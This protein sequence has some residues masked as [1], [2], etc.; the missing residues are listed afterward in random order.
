MNPKNMSN[1][2]LEPES[3]LGQINYLID[4]VNGGNTI[5][6][7]A[8]NYNTDDI[9]KINANTQNLVI[10]HTQVAGQPVVQKTFVQDNDDI[11]TLSNLLTYIQQAGETYVSSY[12]LTP[13]R[14]LFF[15]KEEIMSNLI[16][17]VQSL[18][19]PEANS[20]TPEKLAAALSNVLV[21]RQV[22]SEAM[23]DRLVK[24]VNSADNQELR[25]KILSLLK[26]KV[27]ASKQYFD[28]QSSDYKILESF[29]QEAIAVNVD[30]TEP[31][32]IFAAEELRWRRDAPQVYNNLGFIG[33]YDHLLA[34]NTYKNKA[35]D[36]AP[37]NALMRLIGAATFTKEEFQKQ[38]RNCTQSNVVRPTADK[39]FKTL[40]Q[41]VTMLADWR[42]NELEKG[43]T[44]IKDKLEHTIADK[45]G[46]AFYIKQYAAIKDKMTRMQNT[47]HAIY[48]LGDLS[49]QIAG[50][51]S[52][53][54]PIRQE[55]TQK[56]VTI[57]KSG[58]QVL[59]EEIDTIYDAL[60][61]S[62]PETKI[63]VFG[64]YAGNKQ[65]IAIQVISDE[66]NNFS[67]K[68]D[69][70]PSATPLQKEFDDHIA[71]QISSAVI[72]K[73][74]QKSTNLDAIHELLRYS[75][76]LDG[77]NLSEFRVD[78]LLDTIVDVLKLNDPKLD[79]LGA[80]MRRYQMLCLSAL[81]KVFESYESS[82]R[83]LFVRIAHLYRSHIKKLFSSAIGSDRK[84]A[85][86]KQILLVEL[87]KSSLRSRIDEHVDMI[88]N[89]NFY[90]TQSKIEKLRQ[91]EIALAENIPLFNFPEFIVPVFSHQ[92]E[93]ADFSV[94][95]YYNILVD[96][97]KQLMNQ[98]NIDLLV[99]T[100][101]KDA[102]ELRVILNDM[103]LY[104][105]ETKQSLNDFFNQKVGSKYHEPTY[106]LVQSFFNNSANRDKVLRKRIII[107]ELPPLVVD[108]MCREAIFYNTT[109]P[110]YWIKYAKQ[111]LR[112]PILGLTAHDIYSSKYLTPII[113]DKSFAPYVKILDL[114]DKPVLIA[115]HKPI[116]NKNGANS[117]ITAILNEELEALSASS[118]KIGSHEEGTF[119]DSFKN[120]VTYFLI[121][122][123]F[124]EHFHKRSDDM[125]REKIHILDA[126]FLITNTNGIF[127]DR[128]KDDSVYFV[129]TNDGSSII[130][131]LQTFIRYMI[132]P[133]H[134][135]ILFSFDNLHGDRAV[136]RVFTKLSAEGLEGGN[137]N[138]QF[139]LGGANDKDA[140]PILE[141]VDAIYI[142]DMFGLIL[143]ELQAKLDWLHVNG[144]KP[145]RIRFHFA[146]CWLGSASQFYYNTI[147]L[148]DS[149]LPTD[150]FLDK[151]TND[152]MIAVENDKSFCNLF[153]NVLF[154]VDAPMAVNMSGELL[155]QVHGELNLINHVTGKFNEIAQ[156]DVKLEDGVI[157]RQYHRML[158]PNEKA[159]RT[160]W[161]IVMHPSVPKI[162][163]YPGIY[164]PLSSIH[165]RAMPLVSWKPL[166]FN[167]FPRISF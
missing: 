105:L 156:T 140:A 113:A 115:R 93:W 23:I 41:W 129:S 39:N 57:N 35:L 1:K 31:S 30:T 162:N 40:F 42:V 139:L 21:N 167:Y 137:K 43:L 8:S 60:I 125:L 90:K 165:T 128:S 104:V 53:E 89:S 46:E 67:L 17:C 69:A 154:Q 143:R 101:I 52:P 32:D 79:T 26:Q 63:K 136:D 13:Y 124:L 5:S 99:A 166:G 19:K 163:S 81:D 164:S 44:R 36:I 3:L 2:P 68:F 126:N 80:P 76:F 111:K 15:S 135:D 157:S 38:L 86:D 62:Y 123:T 77:I 151:V 28:K 14:M 59:N 55:F 141:D 49:V 6:L 24:D 133:S 61:S 34:V 127:Q 51:V 122:P 158:N 72:I 120:P 16:T 25:T 130:N 48:D 106:S 12:I 114:E 56:L 145:V 142:K 74:L 150:S 85:L 159:V 116:V 91:R 108:L 118:Y 117:L 58:K 160:P 121:K 147:G 131:S 71:E 82:S 47:L 27:A 96:Y 88:E 78:R 155:D 75:L 103:L 70:A 107:P 66:N 92:P 153:K 54:D 144:D 94:A 148:V 112:L 152:L 20:I 97:N 65:D 83:N 100:G 149:L 4:Q 22:I 7:P 98:V 110:N 138:L 102:D 11:A 146:S 161:K 95:A 84:Y 87:L 109:D 134:D 9:I 29:D 37:F 50:N 64:I 119:F 73:S 33:L 10:V 45:E 18:W 132:Q